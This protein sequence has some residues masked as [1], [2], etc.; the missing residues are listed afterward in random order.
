MK[1]ADT[2]QNWLDALRPGAK[3]IVAELWRPKHRYAFVNN[4]LRRL[5]K[6]GRVE[7]N[8]RPERNRVRLNRFYGLR[9]ELSKELASG[10]LSVDAV[11]ERLR[12]SE[13]AG[14]LL[15]AASQAETVDCLAECLVRGG[16]A[17]IDSE[18]DGC[19]LWIETWR[20]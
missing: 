9:H 14:Q 13:F 15:F 7:S 10:K 19:V 12:S 6:S 17:V 2:H 8:A 3:Q 18:Y 11:L 4:E 1:G 5:S 16:N 20:E